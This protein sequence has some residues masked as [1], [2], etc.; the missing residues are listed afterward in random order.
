MWHDIFFNVWHWWFACDAS[1]DTSRKWWCSECGGKLRKVYGSMKH[2][3]CKLCFE[4]LFDS[5]IETYMD[6]LDDEHERMG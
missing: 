1:R 2:P 6:W 3:L 4:R 5:D